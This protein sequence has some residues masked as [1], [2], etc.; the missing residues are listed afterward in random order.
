VQ[1][2]WGGSEDDDDHP[3]GGGPGF[4][5]HGGGG[6]YDGWHSNDPHDDKPMFSFGRSTAA[7]VGAGAAAYG[8]RHRMTSDS[9]Q[10]GPSRGMGEMRSSTGIGQ[11]SVR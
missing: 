7:G 6:G 5:N 8:A 10:A 11:S 9:Q 1:R 3:G 2:L 4:H